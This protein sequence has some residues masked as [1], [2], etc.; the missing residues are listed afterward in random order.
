[1]NEFYAA[2]EAQRERL[3]AWRRDFHRHPELAYQEERT[4]GIVA[5][6]LER[7]GYRIRRGVGKTGVVG[8][9]EGSRSG[10]VVMVRFD[11]DALP[12]QEET[13]AEYASTVPGRMHACGHD[14]HVAMGMGMAELFARWRD[15]M[16]GTLKLI[17]QPAEEGGNGAEAMIRDGALDDPRP[18]IF[19]A[20]HLWN[21]RPVGSVDVTPG[22]VMAAAEKWTCVIRGLGGHGALP[23]QTVDPIVTAA[24]AVVAL[25][26]IVSRNV[27]PLETAVVTVGAIH[28]GDAFNVIPAQVELLGTIRTYEPSA[29]DTAIRRLRDILQGVA[30]TFGAQAEVDIA[31]LTP[32]VINDYQVTSAVRRA[33]EAVL[34]PE[35]VTS[36]ER[37]MGSEDAAFFMR[38]VPGC[39]FFV[40][41]ANPARGLVAPHHNPRFDFDEEA[42]VIGLAILARAA[43]FY[44]L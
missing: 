8:V 38:Q 5:A 22:P 24:H 12:I 29:R 23:H 20:A 34:G 10:P 18:D 7:L 28:G 15:R 13:G 32:A 3:I 39:Y 19:L 14:G 17:F 41:A 44:L 9:L 4:A 25:Q 21:D 6:H 30:A 37:T 40:G 33:A 43:A 2:A 11:M 26:T 42:M 31:P 27:S 16:S 1:M 36:G 35:R